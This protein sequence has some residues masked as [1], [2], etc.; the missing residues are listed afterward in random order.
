MMQI[1]IVFRKYMTSEKTKK[2]LKITNH[3]KQGRQN[4]RRNAKNTFSEI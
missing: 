3:G 1:K 2:K 4:N